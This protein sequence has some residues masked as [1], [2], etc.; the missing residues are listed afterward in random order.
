MLDVLY[1]FVGGLCYRCRAR[2][3][4]LCSHGCLIIKV[5]SC[6]SFGFGFRL[7]VDDVVIII[8]LLIIYLKINF[9]IRFRFWVNLGLRNCCLFSISRVGLKEVHCGII[10]FLSMIRCLFFVSAIYR[11]VFVDV[12]EE[13]VESVGIYEVVGVL[14]SMMMF[15]ILIFIIISLMLFFGPFIIKV[16]IFIIF[17]TISLSSFLIYFSIF[18]FLRHFK[19]LILFLLYLPILE[20]HLFDE[21]AYFFI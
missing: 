2:V 7:F 16:A 13:F 10:I 3:L 15:E 20:V 17:S 11:C 18:R 4:C 19:L 21:S 12:A 1:L 5:I 6:F 8:V 14:V 9:M